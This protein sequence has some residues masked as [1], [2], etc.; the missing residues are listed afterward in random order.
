MES[1]N[2]A[3]YQKNKD[4]IK[5]QISKKEACNLCN[6]MVSHQNIGKHKK[7]KICANNRIAN[8]LNA[9]VLSDI[10]SIK[11]QLEKL[12]QAASQSE[13]ETE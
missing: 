5:A 6:R 1:Y 8:D 3:Y 2:K 11:L 7:S 9:E 12:R 10:L 13:T 4:K